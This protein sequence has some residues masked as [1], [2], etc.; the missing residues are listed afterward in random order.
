MYYNMTSGQIDRLL[1]NLLSA[2][3]KARITRAEADMNTL[4]SLYK[5]LQGLN[6]GD[7]VDPRDVIILKPLLKIYSTA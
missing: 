1:E 4:I 2:Y 5:K 7:S 3:S 6:A